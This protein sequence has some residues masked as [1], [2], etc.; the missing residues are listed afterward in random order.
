MNVIY[1]T[2]TGTTSVGSNTIIPINVA[3]KKGNFITSSGNSITLKRPGY[4]HVSG[5][6][7]FQAAAGLADFDIEKN[8][9]MVDGLT[10]SVS[11]AAST[12]YNVAF[13][14]VVRVYC[15]EQNAILTLVNEGVAITASNVALTVEYEA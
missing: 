15:Y 7:T 8:G 4:Y 12:T 3:R 2:N 14:G 11:T 1:M 9:V 13:D 5:S 10:A 6:I